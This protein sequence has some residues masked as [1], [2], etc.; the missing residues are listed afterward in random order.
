MTEIVN[1]NKFRKGRKKAVKLQQAE[2]NRAL[3]GRTKA[4]KT[5]DEAE[6]TGARH[7]LDGHKLD[8][9]DPEEGL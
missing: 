5:R 8:K 2:Q 3:H 4:E 6:K 1:L 7:R 9:D